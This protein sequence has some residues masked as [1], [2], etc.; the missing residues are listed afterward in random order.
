MARKVWFLILS[1]V[2]VGWPVGVAAQVEEIANPDVLKGVDLV[3]QGDYDS[4]IL[5]LDRVAR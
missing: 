2:L 3:V 5:T 4:A 1:L